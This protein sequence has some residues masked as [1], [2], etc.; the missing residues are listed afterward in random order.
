MSDQNTHHIPACEH[1]FSSFHSVISAVIFV[2]LILGFLCISGEKG[3]IW[4]LCKDLKRRLEE[5][6]ASTSQR[7]DVVTLRSYDVH[8]TSANVATFQR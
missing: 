4:R 5:S 1:V 7:R 2:Y 8:P 6:S 3:G